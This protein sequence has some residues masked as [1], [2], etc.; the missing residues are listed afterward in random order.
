M[1]SLQVRDVPDHIYERIVARARARLRGIAR[2]TVFLLDRGLDS[3]LDP[4]SRRTALVE[5]I[6]SNRQKSKQ[7]P[8]PVALVRE[9]RTRSK[10]SRMCTA[11]SP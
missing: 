1:H 11:A 3:E 6:L 9:D 2:E 10:V 4:R 8:D 5:R 7:M